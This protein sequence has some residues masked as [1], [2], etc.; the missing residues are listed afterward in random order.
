[1]YEYLANLVITSFMIKR[2]N[3]EQN[4]HLGSLMQTF[5]AS[6]LFSSHPEKS[7]TIWIASTSLA[8][9]KETKYV[10]RKRADA[11][12][13]IKFPVL[14]SSSRLVGRSWGPSS[15][16]RV[17]APANVFSS[18]CLV[19]NWPFTSFSMRS[20]LPK[21]FFSVWVSF[22]QSEPVNDWVLIHLYFFLTQ[23]SAAMMTWISGS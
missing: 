3:D 9:Q 18:L 1:M 21:Q 2:R 19:F 15:Q 13:D 22:S 10:R 17:W 8:R 20:P 5:I 11:G 23:A 6:T 4:P 16:L 7:N 12:L 14:W